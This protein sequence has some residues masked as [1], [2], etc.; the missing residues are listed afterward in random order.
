MSPGPADYI[1]CGN[2]VDTVTA[3]AA[4]VIEPGR[5]DFGCENVTIVP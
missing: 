2:G 1:D 5:G 4:D 3:D